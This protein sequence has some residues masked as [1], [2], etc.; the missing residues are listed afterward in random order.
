MNTKKER[1]EASPENRNY[2]GGVSALIFWEEIPEKSRVVL[3]Q[4]VDLADIPTLENCHNQYINSELSLTTE[5]SLNW[6][7]DLIE[8]KEDLCEVSPVY[9]Q[10]AGNL[11]IIRCGFLL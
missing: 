5:R 6:L 4:N 7:Y 8:D 1:R 10:D 2:K 9:L 3:L 11:L